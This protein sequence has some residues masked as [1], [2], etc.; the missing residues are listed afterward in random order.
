[1]PR[2]C[3]YVTYSKRDYS[4]CVLRDLEMG[5][6]PGLSEWAQYND[7]GPRKREADES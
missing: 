1:M 5:N 4:A 6:V 2:T 3:E 7:R